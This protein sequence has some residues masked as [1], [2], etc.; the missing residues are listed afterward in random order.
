MN[1]QNIIEY[2]HN[3]DNENNELKKK[4]EENESKNLELQESINNFSKF[5]IINNI[6][7]PSKSFILSISKPVS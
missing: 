5:S 3:L 2:I 4:I 7:S 6:N 1:T